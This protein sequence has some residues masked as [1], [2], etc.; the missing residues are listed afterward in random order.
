VN[1]RLFARAALAT[2]LPLLLA[3]PAGAQTGGSGLTGV[4]LAHRAEQ[5]LRYL[6]STHEQSGM[7]FGGEGLASFGRVRL[8]V[9]GVT[10]RLSGDTS[11]TNP[12]RS[13][14]VSEASLSLQP[15]GWLE[16]GT[17]VVARRVASRAS[18]VVSRLLGGHVGVAVPLGVQGLTGAVRGVY[19]PATDVTGNEA[20]SLALGGEIGVLYAPSRS[21]IVLR[22]SYRFERYDYA[23]GALGPARLEQVR[24]VVV[25]LGIHREREPATSRA[26]PR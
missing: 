17:D 3:L 13:V 15:F 21:G 11:V 12:D 9:S 1:A 18:T 22:L 26:S 14:R 16:F 2:G 23:A 4:V 19:Y 20:L 5:R 6:G 24:A 10:G 7:W 25:G 8:R